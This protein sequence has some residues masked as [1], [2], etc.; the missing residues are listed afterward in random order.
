MSALRSR[1][2]EL[3]TKA[4]GLSDRS[5]YLRRRRHDG[6]RRLEEVRERFR[7]AELDDAEARMRREAAG[8]TLRRELDCEPDAA[9]AADCPELADGTSP[10]SRVRELERELRLMGPVKPLDL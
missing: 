2:P 10:A 8:D 6:E 1:R 3:D 4:T 5:A 9:L 7:R